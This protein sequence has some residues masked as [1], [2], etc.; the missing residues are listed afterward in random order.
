MAKKIHL[1]ALWKQF[2]SKGYVF[3]L[4]VLLGVQLPDVATGQSAQRMVINVD[5]SEEV[6]NKHIYGHFAEHLGRG[7]YDGLWRE[8]DEGN[9]HIRQDIVDALKAIQIPNI[10]W[11]GGCFADYYFWEYGI[12]PVEERPS[13]INVLWGG[14]VDNNAVGTHEFM[15]LVDALETEP[16]IVGNVGSGTVQEMARWWEYMTHPGPG[17]MADLRKENG[18]EDPWN[19]H[20][21]GVGNESWGCGGHM[22]PQFYADLY[23]QFATFLHPMGDSEPFRIAAGAAGDDYEWTEVLM[24]EAGHMMEGLDLHHYTIT[25][26]WETKKGEALDFTEAEYVELMEGAQFFDE[27]L[28]RHKSIMDVY[29]PE[30]RVWLIVGEW[31]TWHEP[32]E[33]T[34]PGFLHQQNALRDALTA[35]VSFDMFHR[36]LDRVKMANIAQT[37]N[38]LQAMI[39]TDEDQMILT[40]TYHVFEFY[41]VHHDADYLS[42]YLDAGEYVYDDIVLEAV[43]AT[44]SRNDD[45][46]HVTMTN[47]DPHE[48]RRIEI[49]LRGDEFRQVSGRI[50]TADALNAHNTFEQPDVVSPQTFNGARFSDGKLVVDLPAKSLIVLKLR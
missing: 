34:N 5:Q 50:L 19:V 37:V 48:S 9:F 6:I 22:R 31:G 17:S 47:V 25:G 40:P 18:R 30:K 11:P 36:H 24:R 28:Y 39:L 4:V 3:L 38:V 45:G 7:I 8:D 23:K 2:I 35:S 1:N 10:R 44:A 26:S 42:F 16:I 12:G 27:L 46:V 15:E 43:T 49:D 32:L 21:W 20:Y 13:I 29:D 33:G 14:V 41:T